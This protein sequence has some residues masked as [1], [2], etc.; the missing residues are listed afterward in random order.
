VLGGT[1]ESFAQTGAAKEERETVLG[2]GGLFF[3]AQDP[4]AL[5]SWYQKHLG[6]APTPTAKG[7]QPWHT[8]AGVTS[9]TPF[10]EN[11][12]Y[13]GDMK[14]AWMINFR[15]GDLDKFAAQ[16]QAEGIPVKVD[17]EHYPYGRFGRLHDPEGNA[18]ELWQPA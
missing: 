7:Q 12:T 17:P 14:K 16:L 13:F 3:R 18:I 15:V 9:F 11:T 8:D 5:A 1:A 4:D 6:V 10:A 2:I